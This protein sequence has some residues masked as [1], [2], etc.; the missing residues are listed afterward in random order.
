MDIVGSSTYTG[1]FA[2]G[3]VCRSPG[4]SKDSTKSL[5]SCLRRLAWKFPSS[6]ESRPSRPR[7]QGMY[8]PMGCQMRQALLPQDPRPHATTVRSSS[9]CISFALFQWGFM[10]YISIVDS[11]QSGSIP[12][13]IHLLR[14]TS[15]RPTSPPSQVAPRFQ[16]VAMVSHTVPPQFYSS[17]PS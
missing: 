17:P 3:L 2:F 13:P 10:V 5:P 12:R 7:A 4:I 9:P 8:S 11:S 6:K 1:S 14:T 15:R 16:R